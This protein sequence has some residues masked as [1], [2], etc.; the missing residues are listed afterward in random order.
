MKNIP[1]NAYPNVWDIQFYMNDEDGNELLD[2]NG[3][4]KLFA[5]KTNIRFKPLE[6][7]CEDLTIDELEEIKE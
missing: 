6:Y 2:E 5:L 1:Q 4:V 3:K 7:I